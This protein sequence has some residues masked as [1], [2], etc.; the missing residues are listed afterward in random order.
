[1]RLD[2]VHVCRECHKGERLISHNFLSVLANRA[3]A[4]QPAPIDLLCDAGSQQLQ[5][6][7]L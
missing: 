2:L 6:A 1:M 5:Y 7:A 3:I 4:A